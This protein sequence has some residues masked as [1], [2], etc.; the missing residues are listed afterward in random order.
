MMRPHRLD[1]KYEKAFTI[2][3]LKNNVHI[4]QVF[5]KK[6]IQTVHVSM[7]QLKDYK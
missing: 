1:L 6:S 3:T 5:P 2:A 4:L 7:S